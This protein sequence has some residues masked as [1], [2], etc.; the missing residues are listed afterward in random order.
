[1]KAIFLAAVAAA[2]KIDGKVD[3]SYNEYTQLSG[4]IHTLGGDFSTIRDFVLTG[5]FGRM[6][7][8]DGL[9]PEEPRL[10]EFYSASCPFC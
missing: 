10:V 3:E 9:R 4:A 6:E 5:E 2:L 1:M 7:T 8:R